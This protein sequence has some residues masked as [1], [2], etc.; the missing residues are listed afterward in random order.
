[1][2]TLADVG[3]G[4]FVVAAAAVP[5][6]LGFSAAK[7]G[8]RRHEAEL[9][10]RDRARRAEAAVTEAS[11]EAEWFDR[12]EIFQAV[13]EILAVAG[14]VWHGSQRDGA[15]RQD[16]RLIERWAE[17]VRSALGDGVQPVG[18]PAV[19]VLQVINRLGEDEDRIVLRVRVRFRPA[20]HGFA[21]PR[22]VRADFRWT[23]GRVHRA[24]A[25]LSVNTDPLA[26]RVLDGPLIVADWADQ[27][28]L[29]EQ[30]LLELA[31]ADIVGPGVDLGSLVS[32]G[33]PAPQQLVELAHMDGRFDP[34]LLSARIA[35]I[36]QAWEEACTG[37]PKPLAYV[38]SPE[39]FDALLHPRSS[40]RT[41]RMIIRDAVV[42]RWEPTELVLSGA[43]PEI[44]ISLTVSA[45]RYL[46]GNLDVTRA[47]HTTSARHHIALGWTLALTHSKPAAWALAITTNPARDVPG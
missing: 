10:A 28:R 19:N 13:H 30:T 17:S 4:V 37:S 33:L 15:W 22:T 46:L 42:D 44:K 25:L 16:E 18:K 35:H 20:H 47:G 12:D 38:T 39:A 14:D 43:S 2:S 41:R 45:V 1:V 26:G 32:A 21:E 29:R 3:A 36:V 7:A 8:L 40:D 24:W 34:D 11:L 27:D 23:L 5:A 6:K 31:D 9:H